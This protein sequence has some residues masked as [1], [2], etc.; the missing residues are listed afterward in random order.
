MLPFLLANYLIIYVY[1]S[2][3]DTQVFFPMSRKRKA[4]STNLKYMKRMINVK[5]FS[6]LLQVVPHSL[7]TII[8]FNIRERDL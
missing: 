2:F 5:V 8:Y 7:Q 1:I 4:L 6:D 3:T